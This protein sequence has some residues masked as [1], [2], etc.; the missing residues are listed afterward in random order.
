[1][2]CIP[3]CRDGVSAALVSLADM[4]RLTPAWRVRVPRPPRS[5]ESR[6]FRD[7]LADCDPAHA[8]RPAPTGT[9]PTCS[10][11]SAEVQRFWA[12]VVAHRPGRAPRPTRRPERPDDATTTCWRLRRAVGRAGRGARGGR[13]GR[14]GLDL[15]DEQTVGFS[16]R[17]QAHEALIHRLDAEQTAGRGHRAGPRAG[18]RRRRRGARRDVRRLPAVGRL[19]PLPH[20][21]RV[22]LTD[23]GTSVWVQLGRFTGTDP[24][25]EVRYDEDDIA[26]VDDPGSS[27]TRSISGTAEAPRRL[28]LAP[29]RRRDVHA[30]DC[31]RRPVPRRSTSRSTEREPLSTGSRSRLGSTA[32]SCRLGLPGALSAGRHRSLRGDGDR[33]VAGGARLGLGQGAVGGAEPQREGQRLLPRPTWSPV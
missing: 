29:R 30:G 32:G 14:G 11:T 33:G 26:V 22:D 7:V 2:L 12:W 3:G 20:Y 6:R 8:C 15:G 24:D 17:R 27:P 9:R 10:G 21:L 18:R 23:T 19:H 25:D 1:M 13:P 5:A 31:D 4:S 28:A 16:F